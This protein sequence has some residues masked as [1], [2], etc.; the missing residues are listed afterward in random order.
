MIKIFRKYLKEQL[1]N[2]PYFIRFIRYYELSF[3]LH[4]KY[5]IKKLK[6]IY[7]KVYKIIYTQYPYVLQFPITYKCNLDCIMC[8][9]QKMKDKENMNIEDLRH[10]LSNKLFKKIK[11]VGI[12]GGEPFIVSNIDEYIRELIKRL[13]SLR[14]I[15]IITNGYLYDKII[16][17]LKVIK[18]EC[19]NHNIKLTVSIS[20]DGVD[21]TH[22][23]VRGRRGVFTKVEKTCK[24][25]AINKSL[26]CDDFGIICTITKENIFNINEIEVW[27][28]NNDIPVN[29]NIATI[30][31]R[32]YNLDRFEGFSVLADE[33]SK[34]LA[35]EW[36]YYKFLKTFSQQYYTIYKYLIDGKRRSDC[37]FK[38]YGV[39]LMP[40][41]DIAYCATCS[42]T[43]GN[44]LQIAP[45]RLYFKNQEY[46][47]DLIKTQCQSCSHYSSSLTLDDYLNYIEDILSVVKNP[48]KYKN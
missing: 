15:Y 11:S 22:D 29:Y 7:L 6:S 23:K 2:Y 26:Y 5:L 12:N 3:K 35:T 25:I 16:S 18:N 34:C 13:P 1:K 17:K 30:H 4:T 41:G 31:K 44:G 36:F 40:D 24:E 28:E 20:L 27:A 39:T 33:Y 47:N 37:T 48:F 14:F 9:M 38:D 21:E 42:K 46:K 8:G 32:L 10:I 19:S 45:D 43:L